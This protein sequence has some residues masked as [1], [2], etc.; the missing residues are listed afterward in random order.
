LSP[1]PKL[2]LISFDGF[3]YDLLNATWTPNIYKWA[4]RSS[5][6]VNGVRSQYVTYT[7]PNHMSIVTGMHEQDHG[8]VSNY[9]YEPENGKFFDYFNLTQKEGVVNKSLDT[10]WYKGDPIWL[11]NERFEASRRSVSF[12][13]PSGEAS[14]SKPPH[15]PSLYREWRGYRNLSAWMTDVDD[16]VKLFTDEKDPINF[17]AWYIA[18]PDHTLHKNGFYNG[19]LRKIIHQ[20][21]ELFGY[22]VA[23]LQDTGLENIVNV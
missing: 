1:H 7:A 16:I 21:D 15:K 14:Y 3:R 19:E 22:L 6:F 12:Y 11:A 2:L 4:N 10:S 18:E 5:W 17:L 20:L 23:R 9:F 8:I 13:W